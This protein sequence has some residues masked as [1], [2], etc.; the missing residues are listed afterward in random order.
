MPQKGNFFLDIAGAF[1][2]VLFHSDI[3]PIDLAALR[4]LLPCLL[5]AGIIS[6][7]LRLSFNLGRATLPVL[8]VAR[9]LA[10]LLLGEVLA[11]PNMLGIAIIISV[12]CLFSAKETK[13][14]AGV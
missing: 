8:I 12:V 14:A 7:S 3:S 4:T 11:I 13:R 10:F 9:V 5:F 6:V 2:K 1:A